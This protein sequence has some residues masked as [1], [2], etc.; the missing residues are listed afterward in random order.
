MIMKKLSSIAF[1]GVAIVLVT[2]AFGY[3]A[4]RHG[5]H[6]F[7]HAAAPHGGH[8]FAGH[9]PAGHFDGHRGFDGHPGFDGH[10]H[11]NRGFRGGVF[12][13]APFYWPPV[14]PYYDYPPTYTYEAPAPTYWYYCPSYGAYYPTAPSCPEAWVPVPAQ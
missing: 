1:V 14:Y 10:S 13:G 8:G 12:I 3:A 4:V 9:S 7:S 11:F 6:G 5:G 2:A